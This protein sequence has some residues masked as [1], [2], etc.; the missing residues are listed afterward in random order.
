MAAVAPAE[1]KLGALFR[2]AI[3]SGAT[4]AISLHIAR[5]EPVNGR[6]GTGLTALMLA[7]VH[8]QPGVCAK[9]VDAG[10]NLHLTCPNGLTALQ[11][12]SKHGHAAVVDFLAGLP[13]AVSLSSS[14]LES[15]VPLGDA[16][17]P[18][19][20]L[21][22]VASVEPS[23]PI[24]DEK[25]SSFAMTATTAQALFGATNLPDFPVHED[26]SDD[27]DGWLPDEAA[28]APSHDADCAAAASKAQ[29]LLSTHR[30]VST[31]IDWSDIEFALPEVRMT[32][33]A[34]SRGD[35]LAIEE[36]IEAGLSAGIVSSDDMWRAL[37]ADGGMGIERAREVLQYVLDDIGIMVEQGNASFAGGVDTD[38]DDLRAAIEAFQEYLPE[39]GD[40]AAFQMS[41]ARGFDLIKR[42]DEERIGRRMDA[43]LGVLTRALAA[44]PECDWLQIFPAEAFGGDDSAVPG[45]DGGDEVSDDASDSNIPDA[46]DEQID[47]R[48]YVA[49]VR[50]GMDE[51]GRDAVVPRPRPYELTRLLCIARETSSSAR[52]A[53]FESIAAY[54]KARDQ[55]VNANLRLAVHI[56]Y[57]YRGRG[58]PLEDLIQDGNLGLMRAAEKFDFR[59]GFKFS[60]YAT[61][62]V[63]QCITR[64]LADCVRLIRLPVHMVEKVNLFHRTR[65]DL[66]R[67]R[68]YEAGVDEVA[69]RLSMSSDAA[70]R[71]L[72]SDRQVHALEECGTDSAPGTP[73]APSIVDDSADPLQVVVDRSM[74]AAIQ[75]G[76]AEFDPRDRKVLTLRFGLDGIDP[77][78]LEEV[79]SLFN[80]TRERIRQVEAK[81]LRKLR[82]PS[83]SD[84]LVQF[85]DVSRAQRAPQ[86][87]GS[88]EE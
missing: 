37:E 52:D 80:V 2:L 29:H 3:R 26:S 75:G 65:R 7:A 19:C 78:T 28:V 32:Q 35:M 21:V 82:H 56:A 68:D 60:T 30:R 44:L 51:Y 6:D 85:I 42:E 66:S 76:L 67:G 83:R 77:M 4:D 84:L 53:I 74:S 50:N 40:P 17:Q 88:Q 15:K 27:T 11:L 58:L 14:T 8:D 79:G 38:P 5:G 43:A 20:R 41:A 18:A 57:G 64:G 81:A 25:L 73:D 69:E 24:I 55:L 39:P 49:A 36:L 13:A 23:E 1:G 46:S 62:W 33:P 47:F 63:R 70:R 61:M 9:L 54:E 45:D 48:T 59:R 22:A 86:E 12:A 10:A 34:A 72:R 31:E 71:L 87:Q 16:I